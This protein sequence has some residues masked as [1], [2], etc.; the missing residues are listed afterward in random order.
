MPTDAAPTTT[1]SVGRPAWLV[2]APAAFLALWS[3]GYP[4]AKIGLRHAEPLTLLSLRYAL[5]L[6]LMAPIALIL[7]PP[8]PQR[9]I[10]W[11]HLAAVGFLIQV[12]YF[13][14]TYL[15]FASGVS[16]GGVAIIV[17][18]QPI[19]VGI[20]AP[21]FAGERTTWLSWLGLLLG[22]G[23]SA[24]VIAMRSTIA[25][26]APLGVG[27]AVLALA[28]MTAGTLYEKRLGGGQHPVIANLVQ[29]AVGLAGVL[30]LAYAF[31]TMRVDWTGE[32]V[33]ALAYLSIGNS[34]LAISLLLAMIRFGEVSKVSALLY[35]V[36]PGAALIAWAALDEVIP[37]LGWAGMAIA[38]LGVYLATRRRAG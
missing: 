19:L 31:E 12:A 18:M 15:S 3:A 8:L 2:L 30:P 1:R 35:L 23:G 17:S 24:T 28:G 7:R 13:G 14:L 21:L 33:G 37:P 20:L 32:F 38:A 36:P 9:R 5:V 26:E 27:L 11:L 25:V 4:I 22:L 10:D 34:I 29:F 6:V 16:A